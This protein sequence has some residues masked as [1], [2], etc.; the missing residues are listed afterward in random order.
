MSKLEVI[1]SISFIEVEDIFRSVFEYN[2]HCKEFF[3]TDKAELK[4]ILYPF[5]LELDVNDLKA[6]RYA[7][8]S[9]GDNHF[10]LTVTDD[11]SL[12]KGKLET[13][14]ISLQNLRKA[15]DFI[16]DVV[17][18]HRA[19]YSPKRKW[20]IWVSMDD[21]GVIGGTEK[22]VKAFFNKLNINNDVMVNELIKDSIKYKTVNPDWTRNFLVRVFGKEKAEAY[23]SPYGLHVS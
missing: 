7:A 23:L 1:Q 13:W 11:V 16:Q 22:F 8:E 17:P 3:I 9:V 2:Q 12:Y 21:Y 6:L 15:S 4:G 18:F 20:G 10:Y 19:Y 5:C 14:I